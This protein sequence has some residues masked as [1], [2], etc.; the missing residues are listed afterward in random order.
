[1]MQACSCVCVSKPD[2]LKLKAPMGGNSGMYVEHINI[3]AGV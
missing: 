1:M 2:R 3:C